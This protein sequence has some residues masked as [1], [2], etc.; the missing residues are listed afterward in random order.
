MANF[1]HGRVPN[2]SNLPLSRF[3]KIARR[4]HRNILNEDD[5]DKV[6]E[7][8]SDT[9]ADPSEDKDILYSFSEDTF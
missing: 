5:I 3:A 2:K 4:L 6:D 1:R 7:L 8:F 9:Y